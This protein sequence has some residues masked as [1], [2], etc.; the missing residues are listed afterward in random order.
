MDY[1]KQER[2]VKEYI[3][4]AEGFDGQKL[5]TE[6]INHLPRNSSVLE[7][8]MG[9]GKDI[10]LLEKY[11]KVTGSDNSDLFIDRYRKAHPNVDLIFL[12]A[13][14][15]ETDR[16]FQGIYSN[17]VLIHLTREEFKNSIKK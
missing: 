3:K 15:I 5:I 12:D 8:G 2:N 6:L 7:I 11:Y 1:Y 17:K 16:K 4:M 13:I 9:P 14:T 10:P